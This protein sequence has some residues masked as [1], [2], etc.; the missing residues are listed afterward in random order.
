MIIKKQTNINSKQTNTE[1]RKQRE[2]NKKL[3]VKKVVGLKKKNTIEE[4]AKKTS[5]Y[6]HF[7]N[8]KTKQT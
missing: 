2:A 3:T 5:M 6:F 8:N 7:N 1:H 4:E